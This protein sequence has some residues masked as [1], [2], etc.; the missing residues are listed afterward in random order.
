MCARPGAMPS[1]APV[2]RENEMQLQNLLRA[3]VRLAAAA[4]AATI[5]AA[6]GATATPSPTPPP[7][8]S[9]LLARSL[10]ATSNLAGPVDVAVT[11]DG[12]LAQSDGTTMDISG[13]T[14][15]ATVDRAGKQGE[16]TVDLKG[17][18]PGSEVKADLRVVG[19]TAYVQAGLLGATWYSLPL[20]AARA[21]VPS[22]L[23]EPSV[24]PSF[25]PQA[26]LSPLLEDPGVKITSSGTQQL[27]GRNQ[28]VVVL[29]VTGSSVAAWLQ[30]AESMAGS[31]GAPM[32]LP[33]PSIAPSMPDLPV[34]FWIDSQ[35]GQLSKAST[36]I[37]DGTST[38]SVAVTIKA[39]SGSVSIQAPPAGETQDAS[40]LLQMLMGSGS[41]GTNPFGNLFGSPAP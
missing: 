4:I 24:A 5:V 25:D 20:S 36:S 21:L 7:D 19:D 35:T 39:H 34:T 33:L 30:Q 6:C 29:T 40:Q 11:L 27:D 37:T 3:G 1:T 10:T 13:S 14:I 26:M 12:K 8:P 23:P 2:T 17:V 38:L 22:A 15:T 32:G 16:L 41:G 31:S 28:D 18:Q 9:A